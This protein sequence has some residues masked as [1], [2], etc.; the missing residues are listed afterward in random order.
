LTN[1]YEIFPICSGDSCQRLRIPY[2]KL[3]RDGRG[4]PQ[5]STCELEKDKIGA[6]MLYTYVMG[7]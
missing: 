2:A 1:F 6:G 4:C 5:R 7:R 3:Y